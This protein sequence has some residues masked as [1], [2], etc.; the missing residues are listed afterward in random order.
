MERQDTITDASGINCRMS[1][2]KQTATVR[3]CNQQHDLCVCM[4]MVAACPVHL[5]ALVQ[6]EHD[7]TRRQRFNHLLS[8]VTSLNAK[9][10]ARVSSRSPAGA[11]SRVVKL[12]LRPQTDFEGDNMHLERVEHSIRL[13]TIDDAKEL[14]AWHRAKLVRSASLCILLSRIPL[15]L[16]RE[17]LQ[18]AHEAEHRILIYG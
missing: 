4:R 6:Y 9:T 8:L 10:Y 1:R 5:S 14:S 13:V 3:E 15:L 12:L 17:V 11:A 18:Y 7:H 2:E 16:F